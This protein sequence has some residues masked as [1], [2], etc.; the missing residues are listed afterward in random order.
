[1][2]RCLDTSSNETNKAVDLID[3]LMVLVFCLFVFA[4]IVAKTGKKI[5]GGEHKKGV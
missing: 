3:L 5:R 4:T 2:M 1:M